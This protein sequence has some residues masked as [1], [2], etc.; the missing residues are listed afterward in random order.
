MVFDIVLKKNRWVTSNPFFFFRGDAQYKPNIF[1]LLFTC[2]ENEFF[3]FLFIGGTVR[4]IWRRKSLEKNV[5]ILLAVG[6]MNVLPV[7]CQLACGS[8][9]CLLIFLSRRFPLS[10]LSIISTNGTVLL[11]DCH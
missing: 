6:T 10:G 11:L 4:Y 9:V 8:C 3:F 1:C 2:I 5:D 7:Y